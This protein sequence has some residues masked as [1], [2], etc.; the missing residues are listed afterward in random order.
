MEVGGA[1]VNSFN[2]SET[3]AYLPNNWAARQHIGRLKA[4]Y[5]VGCVIKETEDAYRH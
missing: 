5:S 3:G 4:S 1:P 2:P